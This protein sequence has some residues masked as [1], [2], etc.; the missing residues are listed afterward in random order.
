MKEDK[1]ADKSDNRKP[2]ESLLAFTRKLFYQ[3][4][5]IFPSPPRTIDNHYGPTIHNTSYMDQVQQEREVQ[6]VKLA[7]IFLYLSR[8]L[9]PI[10]N[11]YIVHLTSLKKNAEYLP[12]MGISEKRVVGNKLTNLLKFIK[13]EEKNLKTTYKETKESRGYQNYEQEKRLNDFNLNYESIMFQESQYIDHLKTFI[14]RCIISVE[15]IDEI[16]KIPQDFNNAV[17]KLTGE[18]KHILDSMQFN[19]LTRDVSNEK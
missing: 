10:F 8:I 7:S 9:Q 16:S 18:E 14:T 1:S 17:K 5:N 6:S 13:A 19:N 4:S 3:K 11:N 12:N 2:N 15:F